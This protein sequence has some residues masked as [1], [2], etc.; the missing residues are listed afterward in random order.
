[1]C[2]TEKLNSTQQLNYSKDIRD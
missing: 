1:M 2:C